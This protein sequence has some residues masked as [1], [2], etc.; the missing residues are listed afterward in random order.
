MSAKATILLVAMTAGPALS[1]DVIFEDFSTDPAA[2]WNFVGDQVMGG[3]SEGEVVFVTDAEHSFAQLTGEVRTENN[4]GFIQIRRKF[5][6]GLPIDSKALHMRVRGNDEQ[7]FL[8]IQTT[9]AGRPWHYYQAGFNALSEWH[10]VVI[11]LRAF[12]ASV[13]ALPDTIDPTKVRA[14][15]IVAYGRDHAADISVSRIELK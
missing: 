14:L 7:Y 9:D 13:E 2:R 8:H 15:G 3:V 5:K 11:P 12:Q 4:G 1:G 6:D 10:D